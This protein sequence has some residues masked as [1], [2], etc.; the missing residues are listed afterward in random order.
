MEK[1]VIM[2][3]YYNPYTGAFLHAEVMKHNFFL[4]IKKIHL[5][6]FL[7]P[8]I[9]KLVNGICVIIFVVIMISGFILWWPKESQTEESF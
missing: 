5:Y 3:L 2:S 8:K 6:L 7:P 9:G 4:F 1:K